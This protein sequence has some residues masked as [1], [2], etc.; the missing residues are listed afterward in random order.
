M[1]EVIRVRQYLNAAKTI[2]RG[3]TVLCF[4]MGPWDISSLGTQ[5]PIFSVTRLI[6]NN[7]VEKIICVGQFVKKIIYVEQLMQ[8]CLPKK[9]M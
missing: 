3:I 4:T 8:R 2:K 1:V 5:I 7:Y 9:L 6:A